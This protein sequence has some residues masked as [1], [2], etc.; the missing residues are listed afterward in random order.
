MV[1]HR[2][3]DARPAAGALAELRRRNRILFA[4]AAGCAALL[5]AF[6]AGIAL[7]PRTI[8]G[9][10][11]W[12]KPAKF[13]GSI[14]LF[15]ATLGWLCEHLRAGDRTLRR[16]SLGIAAGSAV[17][18]A[19]IGGQAAR[20]RES[21]FNDATT[22]DTAIYAVMGATVVAMMLLV[23]WLLARSWRREFAVAPAFAWGI[24]L[25]ILLFV[26]GAFEGGAMAALGGHAVVSG[27]ELPVVG[28]VAAGDFRVAHFL[29]LHALQAL[30]LA[31]YAAA[32]A[33]QRGRLARPTRVVGLVAVGYAAILG[34]AFAHAL[35]SALG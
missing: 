1:R 14:A 13:A 5:V 10:P 20:G 29:G 17:E 32:R 11:A 31:G 28:W 9:D 15:T 12:L 2:S 30:P 22:L 24:R 21:H 23:A 35:A 18:L 25:G 8:G 33:G 7:D 34:A 16:A 6:V 19:L 26:V 3:F 27:P 4:T